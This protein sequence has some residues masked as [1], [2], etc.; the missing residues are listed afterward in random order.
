MQGMKDDN[1]PPSPQDRDGTAPS[2]GLWVPDPEPPGWSEAWKRFLEDLR[3]RGGAATIPGCPP[4][5]TV[6]KLEQALPLILKFC[7]MAGAF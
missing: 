5:I 3:S 1:L 4:D 7:A 2:P 6:E